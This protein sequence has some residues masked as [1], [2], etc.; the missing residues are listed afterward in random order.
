MGSYKAHNQQR[1]KR[2]DQALFP[3]TVGNIKCYTMLQEGRCIGYAY[4]QLHP[5]V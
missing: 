5:D 4:S 1:S 2:L 3:A